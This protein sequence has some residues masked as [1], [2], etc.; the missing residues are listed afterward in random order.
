MQ[1]LHDLFS[2]AS[3]RTTTISA[4]LRAMTF[5]M[6]VSCAGLSGC[7]SKT[8][9]ADLFGTSSPDQLASAPVE[10][11]RTSTSTPS[12]TAHGRGA[13][14]IEAKG[15]RGFLG[16]FAPYRITIQQGN[17]VSSE[18]LT[19]LKVGMTQDQVRFALGT[20]L[21]DDIFHKDR[22][23]YLFRLQRGNGEVTTSRVT[24]FFKDNHL[25]SYEGGD[26]PTESEYL[27]RI[28]GAAPAP[29]SL[30]TLVAPVSAPSGTGTK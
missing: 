10:G 16:V 2:D 15:L 23:D 7:A 3:I 30:P 5:L 29:K 6:V 28:A 8:P 4:P 20:P 19:Q 21:L 17:F 25:A 22:W 13:Q 18:M 9:L 27:A 14:T 26:L 12:A 11:T 24:V 1:T